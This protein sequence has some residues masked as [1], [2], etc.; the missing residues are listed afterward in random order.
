MGVLGLTNVPNSITAPIGSKKAIAFTLV[1]NSPMPA[2]NVSLSVTTDCEGL[3]CS[4]DPSAIFM[5]AGGEKEEIALTLSADYSV[6]PGTFRMAIKWTTTEGMGGGVEIPVM[7]SAGEISGEWK[8]AQIAPAPKI[9]ETQ[10]SAPQTP[11]MTPT[12][13]PIYEKQV[14]KK[15]ILERLSLKVLILLLVVVMLG[16]AVIGDLS[17][18]IDLGII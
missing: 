15:P 4:L 1:N 14:T 9:I 18:I 3:Q 12:E 8:P 6:K 5:L 10:A 16:I 7:V 11:V 2:N 17:N 13:V